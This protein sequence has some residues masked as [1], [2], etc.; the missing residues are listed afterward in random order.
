M[1]IYR[2]KKS[3][4]AVAAMSAVAGAAQAQSSVTVYGIL[5]VGFVN[6]NSSVQASSTSTTTSSGSSINYPVGSVFT[7]GTVKQTASVLGNSAE[8]TS[9]LGF[10]GT[11]DLGG[12]TSAFFTAEF[13]LAPNEQTLS[14]NA[15][16]GLK[17]RQTFVGLKKNGLGDFAVGTQYTPIHVAMSKTDAGQQN[18]LTGSVIYTGQSDSGVVGGVGGNQNAYTTRVSNAITFNSDVIAGFQGHAIAVINNNNASAIYSSGAITTGG[19]TNTNGW[20]LGLDY[21]WNKFFGTFNYQ[22]LKQL[23]STTN[24]TAYGTVGT[25][26][27]ASQVFANAS[28]TTATGMATT[29]QAVNIQDNQMYAGATYDF[30]ILKGFAN[31]VSRKATDTANSGSYQKRQ[32]EEIG[33]RS[34]ITPTVEGWASAGVG[35]FTPYGVN[36]NSAHFNA[37]QLGSN[38]W[39]SKRTNLY[40]I[41]GQYAQATTAYNTYTTAGV[42]T[43]GQSSMNVSNFALGVRH[44]F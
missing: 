44:T 8:Q 27:C 34:F 10:K 26:G 1:E 19:A 36:Q 2:M 38:Y 13:T 12:G 33:V 23:T 17:N 20:G 14:G 9:R 40:A 11:E 35:T 37:W 32:A 42:A 22:A 3:L 5:D 16:G 6:S 43:T 4:F 24:C 25:T 41:Y 30:G 7:N 31:W 29:G 28:G 39:L 15:T 21:T 18:N